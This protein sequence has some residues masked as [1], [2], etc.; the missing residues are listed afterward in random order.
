MPVYDV[1]VF[2]Y[3]ESMRDDITTRANSMSFSFFLALFPTMIFLFTL[4][5]LIPTTANYALDIRESINGLL[6]AASEEYLFGVVDD[7]VSRQRSGLLSF[8]LILA[9]FFAS[10]GM[11][12]MMKGF[13]KRSKTDWA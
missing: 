5:P 2:I 8:G 1:A 3:K 6:P 9:V 11:M 7:I 13:E 10:N 4:L 12:S